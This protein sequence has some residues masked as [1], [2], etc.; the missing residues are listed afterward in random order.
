MFSCDIKAE[1]S[2]AVRNQ[3]YY[4]DLVIKEFGACIILSVCRIL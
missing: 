2:A 1:F 4:A 3:S